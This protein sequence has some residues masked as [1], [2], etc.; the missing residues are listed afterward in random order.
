M[1]K[2]KSGEM[3][4]KKRPK[5]CN[6]FEDYGQQA[7][8]CALAGGTDKGALRGQCRDAQGVQVQS[9]FGIGAPGGVRRR[10]P[11]TTRRAVFAVR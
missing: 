2:T 1:P 11:S 10:M 4:S 5:R 8:V 9:F 6:G 7:H 3:R